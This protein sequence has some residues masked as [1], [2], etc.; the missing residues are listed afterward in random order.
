MIIQKKHTL[1]ILLFAVFLSSC[2]P[3]TVF[4]QKSKSI[5]YKEDFSQ[6]KKG[7]LYLLRDISLGSAYDNFIV[8]IKTKIQKKLITNF[9]SKYFIFEF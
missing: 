8:T 1:I 7:V 4:M 3:A 6:H 2:I 9:K 5:L